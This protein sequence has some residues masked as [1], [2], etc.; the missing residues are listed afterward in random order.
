MS[1]QRKRHGAETSNSGPSPGVGLNLAE[2]RI[3]RRKLSQVTDQF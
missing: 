2:N 3:F 1:R